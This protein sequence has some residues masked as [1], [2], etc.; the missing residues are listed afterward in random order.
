MKKNTI[1]QYVIQKYL[2]IALL[3]VII[4][5]CHKWID[6]SINTNPNR[7]SDVTM[8][9]LLPSTQGTLAYLVGGEYSRA[10]SMWMQHLSG[11][12]RQF[13][14]LERYA[15]L[16]SEQ[17]NPWNT[18]YGV[19]LKNI[20]VLQKKAEEENAMQFLGISKVMTAYTLAIITD[21]W[22]DAP[23]SEALK[24]ETGLLTPKYDSQ[25]EIYQAMNTLLSEAISNFGETTPMGVSLP[26][27]ADLIFKGN[28]AKWIAVAKSLQVRNALHL[29]KRNG[30]GA[31]CDAINAGGLIDDNSGD[32]QFNFGVAANEKNPRFQFDLQRGDIRVGAKVVD[33]MNSA[34]DPRRPCYF[35]TKGAAGYAGSEPGGGSL[36]ASWIGPSYAGA[37]ASVF[38]LNYFELK[39]IEA[40]AFFDSDKAR[41]ATAYNM[42]I[43]ASLAKHGVSDGVWEAAH[44]SETAA[45][46][47]FEKILTA[48]Y[49][50]MFL[51]PESWIDW[52]RT[53][54]P[55]LTL[56][57]SGISATPRRYLYPTDERVYNNSNYTSGILA[58]GRVWWDE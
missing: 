57:A 30:Y 47:T 8:K 6:T 35:N 31:V 19:V 21:V 39:F 10:A 52:R 54:I 24:G 41:A 23:F 44:A 9:L 36:S 58:T 28:S 51:N 16:E 49:I 5:G 29:S 20:D 42:G 48:K 14:S 40:E 13:L 34:N 11:V 15:S 3:A 50:S 4:S 17:N 45:T 12:D 56:P 46:I 18:L 43:I 26:E 55:V 25:Q 1:N 22:G 7:P 37:G 2:L 53:G 38:F 33:L 27:T 32:F